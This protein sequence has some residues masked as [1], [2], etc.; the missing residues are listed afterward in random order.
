[1]HCFEWIE[2][3][4]LIIKKTGA[5]VRSERWRISQF[6]SGPSAQI[7]HRLVLYGS[8]KIRNEISPRAYGK[9]VCS[10]YLEKGWW[11]ILPNACNLHKSMITTIFHVLMSLTHVR[12]PFS[13][14]PPRLCPVRSV[15]HQVFSHDVKGRMIAFR[16]TSSNFAF[17]P[18]NF[19]R[20]QWAI[21][22]HLSLER[23]LITLLPSQWK[24]HFPTQFLFRCV[25]WNCAATPW[26]KCLIR[27]IFTRLNINFHIW[28]R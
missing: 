18:L 23:K 7:S 26:H 22:N 5:R 6:S 24:F 25:K 8:T 4:A 21:H 19:Q 11:D 20:L 17:I 1:M 2:A 27:H 28:A 14:H 16:P 10:V 12:C 3:E 15:E 13:L 9:C